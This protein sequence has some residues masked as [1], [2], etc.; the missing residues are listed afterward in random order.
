L[1]VGRD[2]Y[3]RRGAFNA[4]TPAG[5]RLLAHEAMHV[6]QQSAASI[7]L[8]A[9][10]PLL[11]MPGE[12][13]DQRADEFAAAFVE[14]RRADLRVRKDAASA[15]LPLIQRHVSYEH[16]ALGDLSTADLGAISLGSGTRRSESLKRQIEL[17]LLWNHDPEKVDEEAVKRVCPGPPWIRTLRLGP[18][19]VLLTYGELN[20]LPDYF[21]NPT[22]LESLKKDMLLPILQVIRQESYNQ[23]TLLLEN[24]NPN[25]TFPKAASSPW[26]WS[27]VNSF[28]ETHDLDVFTGEMGINGVD[29]YNGLLSRNACH[30]APYS[31]HRW[32]NSHIIARDLAMKAHKTSDGSEK[33]LLTKKAWTYHGYA[34][35]FLQDSFSA[36][37]LINKTMVL[38]WWVE[39]AAKNTYLYVDNWD[40]IKDMTVDQQPGI[41]GSHLY[42]PEFPGPSN[43][44]QTAEEASSFMERLKTTRVVA[45]GYKIDEITA[46]QKYLALLGSAVAQLALNALH[47]MF[48]EKSVW[49]G[50]GARPGGFEVWGDDTLFK[51][52]K[53]KQGVEA[54]SETAQL[55]QQA[56]L[57][58]LS[59]GDTGISVKSL[60]DHFPTQAGGSADDLVDLATWNRSKRSLCESDLFGNAWLRIK[61]FA[62]TAAVPRLSP[63]SRDEDR[64]AWYKN[65]ENSGLHETAVLV[66]NGH[67]YAGCN[68]FI[69]ELDRASGKILRSAVVGQR[70]IGGDYLTTLATDGQTLFAATHGYVY[71]ISLKT[72]DTLWNAGVGEHGYHHVSVGYYAG[73]LYAGCNGHVYRIDRSNG[74]VVGNI[75]LGGGDQSLNHNGPYL[76]AGREDH[77]AGIAVPDAAHPNRFEVAWQSQQISSPNGNPMNTVLMGDRL[78]AASGVLLELDPNTGAIIQPFGMD[79]KDG[80]GD[81]R[82]ATDGT[83]IFAGYSDIV[84]GFQPPNARWRT[85]VGSL[86]TEKGVTGHHPVSVL[87]LNGRLFSGCNGYFYELQPDSGVVRHWMLPTYQFGVGDYNTRMATDGTDI[88]IGIN[89][90]VYKF[91]I[92]PRVQKPFPIRGVLLAGKFRTQ[93]ELNAMSHDDMRN[94]LIVELTEHSK[95]SNYQAFDNDTLAGMGAVLVFLR[96]AKIRD[97]AALATMSADDQRKALIV[98]LDAQTQLGPRLQ[99][100]SNMQLVLTALGVDRI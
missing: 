78:F 76:L 64:L 15:T 87:M 52:P 55:S 1:T 38:Q 88:Y 96:E 14:G 71:G 29:H 3:F 21:A 10:R 97:D 30:F 31:W 48:N 28:M 93:Q 7:R 56:L 27:F 41:G 37:H 70:G 61:D 44:P 58:I 73:Q 91:A 54:T 59:R 13:W 6:A 43:D 39:W 84:H 98:E 49:V 77:V 26:R 53:G 22:V 60:R 92:T 17:Q 25:L 5:V 68:G 86:M 8:A 67:L 57:D 85:P 72:W 74:N 2:V 23:L 16:R 47:D 69:Y 42:N 89:G 94:T 51:D 36:G 90:Y 40:L 32:Q 34:D 45:N 80:S 82:L 20:A 4:R 50:S 62:L 100:F 81:V 46:Y 79:Y 63:S 95:Q 9:A 66:D 35:H 99:G 12:D 11:D 19:E 75:D 24:R 65:L 33:A 18:D 83:R